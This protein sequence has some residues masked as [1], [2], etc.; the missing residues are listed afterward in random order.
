MLTRSES[1]RAEAAGR[2]PRLRWLRRV[3][4]GLLAIVVASLAWGLLEARTARSHL[5]RSRALVKTLRDDPTAERADVARVV[6]EAHGEA[7][8]ARRHMHRLGPRIAARLPVIGR[9]FAAVRNVADAGESVLGAADRVL[10][11]VGEQPILRDGALDVTVLRRLSATL[12]ELSTDTAGPVRQLQRTRTGLTPAV[13]GRSVR[14]AQDELADT[15]EDLGRTAGLL[16]ALAGIAGA[17]GERQLLIALENNAELRGTG[18]LISVFAVATTRGGRFELGQFRDVASVSADADEAKTVAAPAD[19]TAIY[20]PFLANTT[21]WKNANMSP[22]GPDSLSV[23][24]GIAE[25]SL[26][27]KPTAVLVLD[28]PA[29]AAILRATGPV[30]LPTGRPVSAETVVDELLVQAYEDVPDTLAGQTERRRRLRVTAD[31]IVRR[32]LRG[33]DIVALARGLQHAAAGRHLMLWSAVPAEQAAF[34]ASG[35]AGAVPDDGTDLVNVTVQNFGTGKSGE[36]NKL[37]FYAHRTVRVSVVID[38]DSAE[39][40]QHVTIVNRSPTSGLPDYV[41]G[42]TNPGRTNNFVTFAVPRGAELLA[43][44]RDGAAQGTRFH[45]EGAHT[46]LVGSAAIDPG[47]QTSW[48]LRYR[49]RLTRQ[50]YRLWLVPQP[51]ARPATLSVDV[52]VDGQ[53]SPSTI[54]AGRWDEVRQIAVQPAAR[55]WWERTRDRVKKFWD[56]PVTIG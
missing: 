17:D 4:L 18:G 7:A 13:V 31:A 34:V 49:T 23:M 2:R 30:E 41:A 45:E 47:E 36:G 32:L 54:A 1:G 53:A 39:T 15:P 51:L 44:E 40:T 16:G 25:V 27:T 33:G 26:K 14:E 20:G 5:E 50:G 10:D 42:T 24:A 22:I 28:V 11:E 43:F 55:G 35:T 12:G 6:A 56:E 46:V 8:I 38:A 19:Y 52:T 29:I 9:S 37:D 48:T 3:V 21:L